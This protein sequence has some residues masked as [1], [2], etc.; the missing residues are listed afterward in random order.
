MIA[1]VGVATA[2]LIAAGIAVQS[3]ID[4]PPAAG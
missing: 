1:G 4:L 2:L 3:E